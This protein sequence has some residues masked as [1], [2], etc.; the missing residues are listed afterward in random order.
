MAALVWDATGSRL[1]ETG[2]DHGVLYTQ[3]TAGTGWNTGVAWNGLIS[4]TE[5]P[6]GGDPNALY[7]DNI[8]YLELRGAEEFGATIEAYTYP[9]EFNACNGVVELDGK[10]LY[11]GQQTR[12]PFCMAYRTLIGSDTDGTDHGYKIHIIYNA[13]VSPSEQAHSTVN[14][15]P[16][17]ATFSWEV[18]TVPIAVS[19]G[20]GIYRPV[21]HIVIDSTQTPTG[22]LKSVENALFGVDADQEH[23]IS[24][25]DPTLK[26]PDEIL[27]LLSA[28]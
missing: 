15:S 24:A 11:I 6:S 27:A 23:S 2:V 18:S 14:E 12:K 28:T 9:D 4:V 1:Y 3:N 20:S 10:G 21:A 19:Y 26:T 5:S 8:K 13:T 7:A 16:E 25:S 22:K 17:A